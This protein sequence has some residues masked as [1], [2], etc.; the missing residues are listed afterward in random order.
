MKRL[1]SILPLIAL[2]L[3]LLVD[4]KAPPAYSQLTWERVGQTS[5][6]GGF[7]QDFKT[8]GTSLYVLRQFNASSRI[9]FEKFNITP[10]GLVRATAPSI[11]PIDVKNGTVMVFI[12]DGALYLLAGGAYDDLRFYFYRLSNGV[13]EP[14]DDTPYAQG[15]GDAMTYVEIDGQAFLYAVVGAATR[16]RPGAFTAF[17]RFSIADGKWNDLDYPDPLWMCSDDGSALAWD[18][19]DFIYSFGGSTCSDGESSL[20]ARYSISAKEWQPRAPVPTTVDDG[21]SLVWDGG[22]YIY[23]TTGSDAPNQG[24]GFYRYDLETQVWDTSLPELP[25]SVGYYNGN[26]IV[27]VQGQVYNWQGTRSTWNDRADCDG[28]GI[29][30]L[31]TSN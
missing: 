3:S 29:Y 24:R 13:W 14:L 19:G 7:G 1:V 20:F 11:P 22:R 12:P 15:A 31:T 21:G 23:A 6:T 5:F 16:Q 17:M 18:G 30:L 10:G 28:S 4:T 25:C 2:G 9:D 8:D 26:R 27:I